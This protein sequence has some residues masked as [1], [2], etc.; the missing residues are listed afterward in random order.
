VRHGL[1][2][3]QAVDEGGAVYGRFPV[4]RFLC[5]R[6]GPHQPQGRTF[7]VLPSALVPRRRFSLPLMLWLLS[8][9]LEGGKTV[10]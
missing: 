8:L 7:S 9:V 10:R 4:P 1:Y 6:K 5:R 2:F 3:R